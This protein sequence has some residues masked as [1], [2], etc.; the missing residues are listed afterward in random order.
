MGR[1]SGAEGKGR[2]G[3]ELARSTFL[4]SPSPFPFHL[5]DLPALLR[6]RRVSDEK[7]IPSHSDSIELPSSCPISAQIE[8]C[9]LE[10]QAHLPPGPP[11]LSSSSSSSSTQFL[12]PLVAK[13]LASVILFGVPFNLEKVCSHRF[14][15]LQPSPQL[16]PPSSRLSYPFPSGPR[17]IQRLLPYHPRHPSHQEDQI[18]VP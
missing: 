5:A 8:L 3:D 14:L 2:E 11:S 4:P 10:T 15:L 6:S 12:T 1:R 17:R 9:R 7:H 16:T 13:G 18:L